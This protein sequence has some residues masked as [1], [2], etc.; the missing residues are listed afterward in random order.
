MKPVVAARFCPVLFQSSSSTPDIIFEDDTAAHHHHH[1]ASYASAATAHESKY[2]K[3]PSHPHHANPDYRMVLAVATLDSVMLYETEVRHFSPHNMHTV[4]LYIT[5]NKACPSAV[6]C[7]YNVMN[8]STVFSYSTL[9][10]DNVLDGSLIYF[11]AYAWPIN[12]NYSH[13]PI[14]PYFCCLCC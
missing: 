2:S 14:C 7:V 10:P 11:R 1:D 12:L 5:N 4:M 13:L 8:S 9:F 6:I 3:G